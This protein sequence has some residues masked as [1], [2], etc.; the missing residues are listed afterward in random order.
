MTKILENLRDRVVDGQVACPLTAQWLHA[1]PSLDVTREYAALA[2]RAYREPQVTV[3]RS[4]SFIDSWG[5]WCGDMTFV[6]GDTVAIH[7]WLR[8]T[9][10]GQPVTVATEEIGQAWAWDPSWVSDSGASIAD[11]IRFEFGYT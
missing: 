7:Q 10:F 9:F 6:W 3:R 5:A 8:D 4:N 1:Q 11:T 2:P